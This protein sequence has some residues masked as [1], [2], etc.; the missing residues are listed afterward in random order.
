[1]G[2]V[3]ASPSAR[4]LLPQLV[5]VLL[6]YDWVFS[7]AMVDTGGLSREANADECGH[8]FS[9]GPWPPAVVVVV[10]FG[11]RCARSNRRGRSR[12]GLGFFLSRRWLGNRATRDARASCDLRRGPNDGQ[13]IRTKIDETN[14]YFHL[15]GGNV[16]NFL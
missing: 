3:A 4:G 15:Y 11:D 5:V 10:L 1:M 14:R 8:M 2:A 12:D 13:K 9:V 7:R 6:G 16:G